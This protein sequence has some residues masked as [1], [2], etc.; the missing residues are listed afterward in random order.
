MTGRLLAGGR[1]TSSPSW[2]SPI[3]VLLMLARR[4]RRRESGPVMRLHRDV[5][6]QGAISV[7]LEARPDSFDTAMPQPQMLDELPANRSSSFFG[8]PRATGRFSQLSN[9]VTPCA[10]LQRPVGVPTL[11]SCSRFGCV[12]WVPHYFT[13]GTSSHCLLR[14]WSQRSLDHMTWPLACPSLLYRS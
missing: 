4:R 13:V 6:D 10:F 7:E 14:S 9:S 3:R 8:F 5:F 2:Q 11:R 12:L 1:C